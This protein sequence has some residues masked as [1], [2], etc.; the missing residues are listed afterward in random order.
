M[1]E[2]IFS[3]D[4][5][6]NS[7][8][9]EKELKKDLSKIKNLDKKFNLN[10]VFFIPADLLLKYRQEIKKLGKKYEI[11][12][13]GFE[14]EVFFKLDKKEKEKRIRES[15]DI[16]K[17][18]FNK[19]PNWFRAPQF[20]ADFQLIEILE[21]Y[22]FKYDSSIVQFPISQ[23][24]FFPKRF[25]LYLKQFN[26]KRKIRKRKMKIKEI[27]VSSFIFPLS[28]FSLRLFPLWFF[29]IISFFSIN[30]KVFLSHSY[31]FGNKKIIK[32]LEK[33]LKK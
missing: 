12:L 17:K 2:N 5:E 33:F 1:R 8:E 20:S 23:T 27:P 15:V 6:L 29:K 7:G 32:K 10:I 26:F 28:M 9:G 18:I 11:G 14:H 19:N 3:I 25:F 21:K 31:E 13:H 30:R 4:V 24:I 16:Y 22:N